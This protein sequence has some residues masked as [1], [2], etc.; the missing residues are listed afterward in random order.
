MT[1]CGRQNDGLKDVH[2]LTPRTCEYGTL[3][4]KRGF[5]GLIKLRILR[6]GAY[7]KL[8]VGPIK[9][10]EFLLEGGRRMEREGSVRMKSEAE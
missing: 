6:W 7:P 1:R 5:A 2:I 8:E 9:S 3:Y 10:S 4:D